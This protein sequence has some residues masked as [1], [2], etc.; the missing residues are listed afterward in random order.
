[1]IQPVRMAPITRIPMGGPG[2]KSERH[3]NGVRQDQHR[4]ET[5]RLAFTPPSR[6]S[7]SAAPSCRTEDIRESFDTPRHYINRARPRGP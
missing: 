7:V 5:S 4:H 6:R 2:G 1:M 3:R